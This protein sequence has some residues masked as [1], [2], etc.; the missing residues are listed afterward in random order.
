MVAHTHPWLLTY[1]PPMPSVVMANTSAVVASCLP[2]ALQHSRSSRCSN[3]NNSRRRS[4]GHEHISSN[5]R[6]EG[7]RGDADGGGN[8]RHC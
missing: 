5:W 2:Q 4:A 8:T 1:V 3:S 6:V 7:C